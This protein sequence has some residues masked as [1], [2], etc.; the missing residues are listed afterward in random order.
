MFV[1]WPFH[2][3]LTRSFTAL[4]KYTLENL[5][6]ITYHYGCSN[7]IYVTNRHRNGYYVVKEFDGHVMNHSFPGNS[8]TL[9]SRTLALFPQPDVPD[10]M[11][12]L[13]RLCSVHS[14]PFVAWVVD[15]AV[16]DTGS[17][18]FDMYGSF[19]RNC[20]L[21][22]PEV[23]TALH[24]RGELRDVSTAR[25]HCSVMVYRADGVAPV[26]HSLS[27]SVPRL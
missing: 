16:V 12:S 24:S 20:D 15:G 2:E 11:L 18:G 14:L 9:V 25:T 26:Q 5:R 27:S 13:L 6:A 3:T 22:E 21:F 19:R 1:P 23:E 10:Y 4:M 7:S 8:A 17:D